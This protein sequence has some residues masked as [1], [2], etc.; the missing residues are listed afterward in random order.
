MSY[1]WNA[2]DQLN[3]ADLNAIAPALIKNFVAGGTINASST[4]QAVY[5]KAADGKVYVADA[6]ADEST[7]KFIGYV[8]G[9][10][11]VTASQAVNV[12]LRGYLAGF[13]GLTQ[14]AYYYLGTSGAVS[15]T[16]NSTRPK[17]VAFAVSTTAIIIIFGQNIRAISDSTLSGSTTVNNTIALGFR[18]KL[19]VGVCEG[20]SGAGNPNTGT[21]SSFNANE[22]A[23]QCVIPSGSSAGL[24]TDRI[25][26]ELDNSNNP[27][28]VTVGSFTETGFTITYTKSGSTVGATVTAIA[29]GE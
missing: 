5:V 2:G 1:P 8:G 12:T 20:G 26:V 16:P 15:T 19:I 4:P 9:G 11:S 22:L 13:T 25:G 23:Q 17:R 18:P 27:Q 21:H 14:N 24:Y 6:G 3:A 29:Y 28:T 7:Y 10:Q